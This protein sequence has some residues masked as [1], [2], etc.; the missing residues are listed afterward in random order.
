[1]NEFFKG[2]V[3]VLTREVEKLSLLN[4]N[5]GIVSYKKYEVFQRKDEIGYDFVILMDYKRSLKDYVLQKKISNK[6][7]VCLVQD[8]ARIIAYAHQNNIIHKNIKPENL[9]VSEEGHCLVGDFSLSRKVESFQ[10]HSQRKLQNVYTAPEVLSEYDYSV[11]TDVYALGVVLYGFL[12]D[13]ILPMQME[14][15][16]FLTELPHPIRAKDKLA[17][18]VLRAIAYRQRDRY[19]SMSAFVEALEQLSESD[20]ELAES[21]QNTL[22]EE[23]EAR[24]QEEIRQQEEERKRQEEEVRRQEEIRQQ[25]EEAKRQEEVRRQ[26][27]IRQQ[28]EEAKRQ[29][30]IRKQEEEARRQEEERKRQEEEVRRQEEIRQQEEE[31]RRQE[32]ERKRQEEE[33]RKQEER[34]TETIQETKEKFDTYVDDMHNKSLKNVSL[35]AKQEDELKEFVEGQV[36]EAILKL[37][38]KKENKKKKEKTEYSSED[39]IESVEINEKPLKIH[40][41]EEEYKGFFDFALA[42]TYKNEEKHDEVIYDK[43]MEEEPYEQ[44]LINTD[45]E[46]KKTGTFICM[47]ILVIVLFLAVLLWKHPMS[48]QFIQ[49]RIDDGILYVS[50][51]VDRW[52]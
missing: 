9:F 7:L 16:T 44:N 45:T 30:E 4:D 35:T 24:R 38:K 52:K 25:E 28:E 8:A 37:Q 10:S 23:E 6:E 42:E 5:S 26:E 19:E 50:K 2:V 31:A 3:D 17:Q 12:N 51:L 32:E 15:R 40:A 39:L 29:E 49:D 41:K 20:F 22:R 43:K 27:E 21:Y 34:T 36:E 33:A 18:V 14:H 48:H 13:G 11:K 1:M 47:L 46:T